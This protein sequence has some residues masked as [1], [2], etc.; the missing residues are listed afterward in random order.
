MK[1]YVRLNEWD[2]IDACEQFDS[3]EEAKAHLKEMRDYFPTQ[4]K[5]AKI[6]DEDFDKVA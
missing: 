6:V 2:L 3:F 4:Y 5:N 1:F